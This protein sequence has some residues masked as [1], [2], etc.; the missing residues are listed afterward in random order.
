MGNVWKFIQKAG[1]WIAL[2]FVFL[3]G[4]FFERNRRNALDAQES[5][6]EHDR[7]SRVREEQTTI[8]AQERID[9]KEL[10]DENVGEKL[11]GITNNFFDDK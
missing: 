1:A 4:F 7:Q 5:I 2:G 3:L 9:E 8:A 11:N 6:A 10:T